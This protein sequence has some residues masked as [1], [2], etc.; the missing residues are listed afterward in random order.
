MVGA[1]LP[2]ALPASRMP[3]PMHHCEYDDVGPLDREVDAKWESGNE[4]GR[5]C[6]QMV[7]TNG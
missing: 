7:L 3:C 5:L 4:T 6:R 1:N 2:A